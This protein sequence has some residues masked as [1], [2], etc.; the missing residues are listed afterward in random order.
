MATVSIQVPGVGESI[1]EGILARWLKP[2]G[3]S[4]QSGEPLYELETDKASNVVPAPAAG[5]LKIKV[6]EGETVAIGADIGTLDPDA[7]ASAPAAHSLRSAQAGPPNGGRP[8]LSPAARR[9][10]GEAHV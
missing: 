7:A 9:L 3:S 5:T 2:D 8:T 4:V 10:G 6:Q 1:S